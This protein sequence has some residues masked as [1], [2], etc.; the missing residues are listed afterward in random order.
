MRFAGQFPRRGKEKNSVLTSRSKWVQKSFPL[1]AINDPLKVV[2]DAVVM[3]ISFPE[4][5]KCHETYRYIKGSGSDAG[6]DRG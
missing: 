6:V 4:T 5:N 3:P 1:K 2:C